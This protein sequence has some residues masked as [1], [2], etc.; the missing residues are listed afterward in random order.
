MKA[1]LNLDE[2]QPKMLK[3]AGHLDKKKPFESTEGETKTGLF[4]GLDGT[5]V[6]DK[7]HTLKGAILMKKLTKFVLMDHT[8]GMTL[9]D[10]V[11]HRGMKDKIYDHIMEKFTKG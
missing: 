9:K 7:E 4:D 6:S 1:K 11:N 2:P 8:D 3:P 5:D 10:V